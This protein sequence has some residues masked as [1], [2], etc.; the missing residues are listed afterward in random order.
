MAEE[1]RMDAIRELGPKVVLGKTVD[2]DEFIEVMVRNSGMGEGEVRQYRVLERE[3]RIHFMR[4]GRAV[5]EPGLGRLAPSI[6]GKGDYRVN[7]N[8]DDDFVDAIFHPF[9]GVIENAENIGKSADELVALWNAMPE[10]AD[11]QIPTS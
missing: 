2:D 8:A 5:H 10:H 6:G 3:T 11:R 9:E 4:R 7:Y 1:T